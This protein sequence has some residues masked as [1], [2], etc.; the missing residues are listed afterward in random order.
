MHSCT[1]GKSP[2]DTRVSY[3]GVTIGLCHFSCSFTL[4]ML[5]SVVYD[6]DPE[7]Y[8]FW[9][10]IPLKEGVKLRNSER[11]CLT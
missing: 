8:T 7:L 1:Y 4:A 10:L 3:C 5:H 11:C 9:S 2:I 6:T